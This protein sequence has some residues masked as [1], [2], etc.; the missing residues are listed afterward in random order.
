MPLATLHLIS[1]AP[2]ATISSFVG[3]LKST[4]VQPL[5]I[6]KVIR[7][8]ITP[9]KIEA[10]TLL[11]PSRP[12]DVL[13]IVLGSDALPETLASQ[14]ACHW[15][16][17]AGIPSRLTKD[18]AS[19]NDGVLHPPPSS[20]P[21]LTG[22]LDTPRLGASSQTLEM[23][24][25][26]LGWIRS[27]K[28]TK[29][30]SSPL[31]MLNLLAFKPGLKDSYLQYGKAFAESIGSRRGGNAKLVGNIVSS[32]GSSSSSSS[33]SSSTAAAATTTKTTTTTTTTTKGAGHQKGWDEF[34]LA[35]YPSILHF[36]DM[37][38]SEDYQAVNLKYRVPA[39]ED[40]LI[41][42]TSEIEIETVTARGGKGASKL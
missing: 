21:P 32:A 27:F 20:V 28:D 39:L 4:A 31:S 14:I 18:F 7:W 26:L 13:L 16:A 37:L 19:T 3:S 22:A 42:C 25:E 5:T 10:D 15:S 17:V 34:A 41:L 35:S 1:L 29:A 24:S 12:W 40:T 36:A 9:T 11:R 8:I 30:G 33:S 38:A 2:T 6:S 23:S